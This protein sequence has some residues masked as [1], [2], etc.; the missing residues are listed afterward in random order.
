MTFQKD[1][2]RGCCLDR[3]DRRSHTNLRISRPQLQAVLLEDAEL[4]CQRRHISRLPNAA[5]RS[6]SLKRVLVITGCSA[7]V[8]DSA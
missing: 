8:D 7:A 3:L 1:F 4:F 5:S 6:R 2:G